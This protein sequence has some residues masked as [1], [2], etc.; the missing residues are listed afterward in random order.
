MLDRIVVVAHRLA[1]VPPGFA[2]GV[3]VGCELGAA[4][5]IWMKKFGRLPR[6]AN[7]RARQVRFMQSRGFTLETVLRIIKH[8]RD[9][10]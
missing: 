1:A 6:N 4:Q 7:E 2:G 5:A 9:E 10:D 3:V 8:G